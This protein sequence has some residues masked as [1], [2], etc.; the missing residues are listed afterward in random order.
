M[1]R[2]VG[3]P[4]KPLPVAAALWSVLWSPQL[5]VGDGI[6]VARGT[7]RRRGCGGVR[8]S[9]GER[10]ERGGAPAPHTHSSASNADAGA[11]AF[12]LPSAVRMVTADGHERSPLRVMVITAVSPSE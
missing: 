12:A 10:E 2:G 4:G 6:S 1:G 7:K 9:A 8:G 3:N 5:A 11:F